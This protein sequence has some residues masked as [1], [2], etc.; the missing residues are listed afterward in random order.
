MERIKSAFICGLVATV[1]VGSML[2]MNNAIHRLPRLG[3][4]RS[5]S[6]IIGFPDNLVVGWAVFIVLGVF[7]FSALFAWAAS[8]IPVKSYL[9]KGVVFGVA[10]W[11]VMMIVFMPLGGQGFFGFD[12][13]L[14]IPA[15]CLILNLVYGVI[16]SLTY[17]WLVGPESASGTVKA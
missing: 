8:R 17:R 16:L 2:L 3:I 5:L 11:L 12:R 7:G 10:C 1:V 15:L 14:I 9:L 6:S 4:G 13:G